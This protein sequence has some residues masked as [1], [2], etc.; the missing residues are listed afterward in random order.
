MAERHVVAVVERE[1]V[2]VNACDLSCTVS[3]RSLPRTQKYKPERY[4]VCVADRIEC[5]FNPLLRD[6]APDDAEHGYAGV[7][8]A[9]GIKK[10]FPTGLLAPRRFEAV[11]LGDESIGRRVPLSQ[12]DTVPDAHQPFTECC[13]FGVKA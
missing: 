6:Q 13:Q 11:A 8:P 4:V 12:V 3:D 9:D 5:K 1:P 7:L 2:R 10:V